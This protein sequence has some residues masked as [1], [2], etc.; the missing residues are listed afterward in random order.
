M[1]KALSDKATFIAIKMAF[2]VKFMMIKPTTADK[3]GVRR[4]GNKISCMV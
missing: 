1:R 4:R 3:V 2:T